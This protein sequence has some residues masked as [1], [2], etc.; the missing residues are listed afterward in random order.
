[1]GRGPYWVHE[2]REAEVELDI[3]PKVIGEEE[4]EECLLSLPEKKK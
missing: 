2:G 4:A 1:M 3:S